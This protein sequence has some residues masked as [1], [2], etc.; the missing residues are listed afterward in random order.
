MCPEISL[1]LD[2]LENRRERILLGLV[3][4]KTFREL[5]ENC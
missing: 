4:W 2:W 1:G 3:G 5:E